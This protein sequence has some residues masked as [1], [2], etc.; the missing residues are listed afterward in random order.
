VHVNDTRDF[1]ARR[2]TPDT[3]VIVVW[4]HL[5]DYYNALTEYERLRKPTLE[6]LLAHLRF[7]FDVAHVVVVDRWL[8]E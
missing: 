5:D 2:I 6:I 4:L 1:A 8:A 3:V 7:I